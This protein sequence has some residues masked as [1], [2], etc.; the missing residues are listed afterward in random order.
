M[1]EIYVL[2][3]RWDI[4]I[5][6]ISAVGI[7]VS[8]YQ[9]YRARYI[10]R[11][12]MFTLERETG[13][14]IRNSASLSLLIFTAAVGAV[15]Y[16]NLRVAPSLPPELLRAPSPTL[17]L[18]STPLSS[19]T[20]L[21]PNQQDATPRPRTTPNLVPTVTLAGNVVVPEA[22]PAL[23]PTSTPELTDGSGPEII[24]GGGDGFIPAGGGCNPAVSISQPRPNATIL[25]T[26]EFYGTATNPNFGFYLLE[27]RGEATGNQWVNI[28]GDNMITQVSNGLLGAV[29]VGTLPNDIYEVRL[30]VLDNT[31]Q[32]TGQC[33]ITLVIENQ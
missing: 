12:A 9:L 21:N 28:L 8:L 23:L 17:D 7:I 5:Y 4:P 6:F 14:R 32:Q 29:N 11:R 10:L 2:L 33:V 1:N 31:G 15:I 18:F 24:T 3:V 25:G 22:P 13:E 16:V 30:S 27:I 20:P 19:P 26:T